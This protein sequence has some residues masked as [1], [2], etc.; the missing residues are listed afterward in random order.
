MKLARVL[1]SVHAK[2]VITSHGC[3]W[4]GLTAI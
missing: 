2:L 4:V 3:L 1:L